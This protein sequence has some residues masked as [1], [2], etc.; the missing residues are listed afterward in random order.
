MCTCQLVAP[1]TIIGLVPG[2]ALPGV[3]RRRFDRP[4]RR[5]RVRL[6]SMSPVLLQVDR[7]MAS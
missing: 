2:D 7:T 3:Q 5:H 4:A 1:A 6:S